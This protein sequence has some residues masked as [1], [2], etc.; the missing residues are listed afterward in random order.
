MPYLSSRNQ[1]CSFYNQPKPEDYDVLVFFEGDRPTEE[2]EVIGMVY[3]EK[4]ANTGIRW[5]VVK[6]EKVIAL[7]KEIARKQGA[8]AIIDVKIISAEFRKRDWKRGKAK[9]IIFKNNNIT[10]SMS[11]RGHTGNRKPAYFCLF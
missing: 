7:L 9:A 3:A 10:S 2:F 1:F 8:D 6:P 11:I 4:E 5:D